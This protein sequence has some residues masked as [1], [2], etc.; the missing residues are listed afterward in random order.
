MSV[1]LSL[2]V[3]CAV[4]SLGIGEDTGDLH[5]VGRTLP[6]FDG[7]HV[8]QWSR[9]TSSFV[10]VDKLQHH[11]WGEGCLGDSVGDI[12][13]LNGDLGATNAPA[14]DSPAAN[15]APAGDSQA[16]NQAPTQPAA[17]AAGA[18]VSTVTPLQNRVET[19]LQS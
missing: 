18:A 6:R 4:L 13:A 8:S 9:R 11:Q 5:V 7:N 19:A 17:A 12:P 16:A 15:Q 3:W 2:V 1:P 10:C 14:G